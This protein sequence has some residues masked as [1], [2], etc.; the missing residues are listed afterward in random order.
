[1]VGGWWL[2]FW[3]NSTDQMGIPWIP[4]AFNKTG[5]QQKV[6]TN[7][8]HANTLTVQNQQKNVDGY[9]TANPK[10]K[11]QFVWQNNTICPENLRTIKSQVADFFWHW[12]IVR[13]LLFFF[14]EKA[15]N[16]NRIR[17]IRVGCHG[18]PPPRGKSRLFQGFDGGFG[19]A[20]KRGG[21]GGT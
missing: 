21:G 7:C 5:T 10:W 4:T 19:L 3:G 11:S 12:I 13:H 6:T 1:M 20:M 8:T 18:S 16:N 15:S 9:L 17:M 2:F 14:M